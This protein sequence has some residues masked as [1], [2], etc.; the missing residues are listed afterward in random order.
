MFGNFVQGKLD[1]VEGKNKHE[2][3][4]QRTQIL[5]QLLDLPVEQRFRPFR[6]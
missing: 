3:T 5:G 1:E 2:I 6:K 4:R